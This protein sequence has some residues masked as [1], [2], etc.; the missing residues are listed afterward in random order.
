MDKNVTSYNESVTSF[1]LEN[2]YIM[3]EYFDECFNEGKRPNYSEFCRKYLEG[4]TSEDIAF[5]SIKLKWGELTKF[6]RN[7]YNLWM[8]LK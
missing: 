2:S 4:T 5:D 6:L 8:E 3:K 7:N 1:L